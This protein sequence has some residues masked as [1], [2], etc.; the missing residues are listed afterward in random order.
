AAFCFVLIM[1]LQFFAIGFL[2]ERLSAS[3]EDV[4]LMLKV[5]LVQQLAIIACPA[6]MMG[7]MLTT[8]IRNTFRIHW[9]GWRML[10][11]ACFLPLI[12]HPLSVEVLSRLQWFFGD[13]PPEFMKPLAAMSDAN[14]PLWFVLLTFAV[15]PA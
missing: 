2:K 12:I 3:G 7:L 10:A 15:A 9:P 11:V 5:I 8:S 4:S 14:L 1:L 6:L 13:L